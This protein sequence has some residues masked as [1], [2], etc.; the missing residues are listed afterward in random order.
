MLRT[1]LVPLTRQKSALTSASACIGAAVIG[2]SLSKS[3]DSST[4]L[5]RPCTGCSSAGSCSEKIVSPTVPSLLS[6]M[7]KVTEEMQEIASLIVPTFEALVRAARLIS[8]AATIAAD[9]QMNAMLRQHPDSAVT[10]IYKLSFESNNAEYQ[11]HESQLHELENAVTQL[12]KDLERAQREY[13]SSGGGSKSH[14]SLSESTLAKREQK[15]TMM[16]IANHLSA[17][18]EALTMLHRNGGAAS[19]LHERNAIRLLDLC[20]TNGEGKNAEAAAAHLAKTGLDCVVPHV[21]WNHT[22]ERVLTMEFEEGFKA[23]DVDQIEESGLQRKDV[24]KLISSVF[25]AQIFENG[26]VHCDPHPAN[27]LLREHP[28]KKGKPQVVLVD[29]GLYKMLD[30]EFQDA[31]ARLWKGIVVADVED[32]KQACASLGVTK[33]YPLLA[34]M[35]TSRPFDEV[36]ER[37]QTHSFDTSSMGGS[38]NSGGDKAMI[39][40]YAQRYLKEIVSMLDIV[41]RQM[42]LIFKMNDCLRHVDYALG[43]PTNTLVVAGKY[44]SERVFNN[45]KQRLRTGRFLDMFR[46]WFSYVNVM[47]RIKTYE[48]WSGLSMH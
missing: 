48:L 19:N 33:M 28:F 26:F 35:L 47:F 8:T 38:D 32:I 43:S 30:T 7:E 45:D 9:Y 13:V 1:A 10:K 6:S 24:A 39:R 18:Q 44:A 14:Q 23:T 5:F 15:E 31:Y 16:T 40:G 42:L 20:R 29:H 27:V 22:S 17:A 25:N 12:E 36:I 3:N 2:A 41:P 46:S 37:S 34:A 11:Q 21:L 4:L